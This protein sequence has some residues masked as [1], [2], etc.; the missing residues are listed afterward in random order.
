MKTGSQINVDATLTNK[1]KDTINLDVAAQW[2][3]EL[4]FK[5]DVRDAQGILAPLTDYGRQAI[6]GEGDLPIVENYRGKVILHPGDTFK[7]EIEVTKLYDLSLPGK[8]TVLAQRIDDTN[9][10]VAKSNTATLTVTPQ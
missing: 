5:I 9:G 10:A 6:K 4:D 8:Y 3:A 2:M 1:S 7:R